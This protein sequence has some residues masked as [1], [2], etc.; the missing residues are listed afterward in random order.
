M[1]I[2]MAVLEFL[3]I[4]DGHENTAMLIRAFLKSFVAIAPKRKQNTS[5]VWILIKLQ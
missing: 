2:R 3:H 1:K 4:T 5:K